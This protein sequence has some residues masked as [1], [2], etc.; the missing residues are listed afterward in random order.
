MNGVSHM[1]FLRPPTE[2]ERERYISYLREFEGDSVQFVA[3]W[4]RHRE[5]KK[6]KRESKIFMGYR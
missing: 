4:K 6:K 1:Q 3:K 5:D 2:R